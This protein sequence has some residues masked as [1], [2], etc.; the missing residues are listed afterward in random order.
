MANVI[1]AQLAL[2]SPVCLCV[3]VCVCVHACTYVC[4]LV[5]QSCLTLCDPMDCSLPGS[6][7][8]GTLQARILEWIFL[9]QGSNSGL[10]HCRQILYLLSYQGSPNIT[11]AQNCWKIIHKKRIH[12]HFV[13]TPSLPFL[14][15]K[16]YEH[17]E[18]PKNFHCWNASNSGEPRQC[19][20]AGQAQ[21]PTSLG[22]L[23]L[24]CYL[25]DSEQAL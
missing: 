25:C 15:Y 5:I 24:C 16:P 11:S 20:L 23:S 7:V 21:E 13:R 18:F 6:S 14:F 3:C 9:T 17:Q 1:L 22:L 4:V 19:W 12:I 10:L 2:I 8:H